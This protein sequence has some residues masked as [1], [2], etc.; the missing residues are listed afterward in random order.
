[1]LHKLSITGTFKTLRYS[2]LNT[3]LIWRS[4][5]FNIG[6]G[7]KAKKH[8]CRSQWCKL[9]I[10]SEKLKLWIRYLDACMFLLSLRE[11]SREFVDSVESLRESDN[12]CWTPLRIIDNGL[13]ATLKKYEGRC[14]SQLRFIGNRD[15]DYYWFEV[16]IHLK[17]ISSF[18]SKYIGYSFQ[19]WNDDNVMKL[20]INN[21]KPFTVT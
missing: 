2:I 10:F 7:E 1:M 9:E 17:I 13:S 4:F 5:K 16:I 21:N 15:Y 11:F 12:A 6:N 3:N 19:H 20:H 18:K 14:M 8:K